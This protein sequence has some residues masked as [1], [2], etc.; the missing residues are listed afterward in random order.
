VSGAYGDG[1]ELR[2][3]VGAT[4]G[5]PSAGND[6][7]SVGLASCPS[8]GRPQVAPTVGPQAPVGEPIN[9]AAARTNEEIKC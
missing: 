6:A 5:R 8:P 2:A 1:G 3:T 4:C 9:R 7:T